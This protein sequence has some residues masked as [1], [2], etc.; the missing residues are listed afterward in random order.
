M[1]VE[2]T[3]GGPDAVRLRV[4]DYG[5]HAPAER[6]HVPLTWSGVGL[7]LATPNP[8]SNLTL[9]LA[10]TMCRRPWAVVRTSSRVS[11]RSH[12]NPSSRTGTHVCPAAP[13]SWR[14]SLQ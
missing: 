5:E 9:T 4:V 11:L 3:G 14:H 1:V 12:V 13:D 7:G 10:L 8:H 6:A 2:G